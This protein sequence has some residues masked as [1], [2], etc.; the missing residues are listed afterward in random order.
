MRRSAASYLDRITIERPLRDDSLDGAGSGTW[1]LVEE[2]V[3]ASVEDIP[4]RGER[5]AEGFTASMRPARVRMRYRE[6]VTSE[7][8][9][10]MGARVMQI[11]AGPAE[12]GRRDQVEFMV[13]EYSPAGSRA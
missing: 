1:L 11:A 5:T 2:N 9:F 12:V 3:P 8:R 7:M 6:D 13:E 4:S 10:V